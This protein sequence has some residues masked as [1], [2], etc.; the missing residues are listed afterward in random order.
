[1]SSD[2]SSTQP[3]TWRWALAWTESSRIAL[4]LAPR[5]SK[6]F[7]K[8][9]TECR[10]CPFIIYLFFFTFPAPQPSRNPVRVTTTKPIWIYS[11]QNLL[12][13][14]RSCDPQRDNKLLWVFPL[15]VL[16]QLNSRCGHSCRGQKAEW[17]NWSPIILAR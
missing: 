8:A 10:K 7:S 6:E 12:S 13:N 4:V 1:M 14:Q 15:S 2:L 11:S 17:G 16:L 5:A 9:N 3:E